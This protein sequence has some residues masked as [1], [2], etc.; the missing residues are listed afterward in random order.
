M[1]TSGQAGG[2]AGPKG[3]TW[4][5]E[6]DQAVITEFGEK[7]LPNNDV[8]VPDEWGGGSWK[9]GV[10]ALNF[11]ALCLADIDTNNNE[12]Y[13]QTMWSSVLAKNTTKLDK[14]WQNYAGGAQT[15]IG[16]LDEKN[17]LSVAPGTSFVAPEESSDITTLRNQCK[18][19]IVDSSWKMVFAKDEA[20][21]NSLLKE[22]QDTVKGLGYKDVLKVDM[23]NA[24]DEANAR[25]QVVKDYNEKYPNS[26]KDE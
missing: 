15:T 8:Q 26:D 21:F 23:K 18:A 4:E 16:F 5:M 25:I 14:D 9:D 12:P 7:A 1:E 2:A 17:A 13:M 22:M 20:E 10:S 6:G 19:V 3:L 24:Q 11:K